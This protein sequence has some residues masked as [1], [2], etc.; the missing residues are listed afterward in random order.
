D[1]NLVTTITSHAEPYPAF[2]IGDLHI[3]LISP[4]TT[5]LDSRNRI[6][7]CIYDMCIEAT[8]SRPL[9]QLHNPVYKP[10]GAGGGLALS[11]QLP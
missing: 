5:L 11:I 2:C 9:P 3:L 7:V 10:P 1:F 8:G 6:A 4:L